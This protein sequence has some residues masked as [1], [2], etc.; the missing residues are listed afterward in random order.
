MET[1]IGS[2]M[3]V[4]LLGLVGTGALATGL[5]WVAQTACAWCG[6]GG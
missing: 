4:G 1:S 6:I 5:G 3:L 2:A